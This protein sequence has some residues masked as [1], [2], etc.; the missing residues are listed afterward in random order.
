[1]RR[2]TARLYLGCALL[3]ATVVMGCGRQDV[4]SAEGREALV[5]DTASASAGL[6]GMTPEQIEQRAEAMSPERAAE[7]GVVDTTIHV[8]P[9]P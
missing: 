6:D 8:P 3:G 2:N 1:M 7:L 5:A 9:E 4:R